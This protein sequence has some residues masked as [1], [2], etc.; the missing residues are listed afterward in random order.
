M[1]GYEQYKLKYQ[2]LSGSNTRLYDPFIGE[3]GN[4]FGTSKKKNNSFTNNYMTEGFFGRVMYDYA[5]KYFVNASLR[6]DA[7]SAFAPGH[8]WGTFGSVGLAWQMN[9]E[10]FLKDVKWID[11]LKL[12]VSYGSVGNDQL[13]TTPYANQ[14]GE[15]YYYWADRY[16]P[17]YNEETGQFSVTM[18]QKGNENL[19]W[20]TH[21]DWNVGVDF[22]FFKNRLTGTI[23]YYNQKTV[24]LLWSKSLPLSSGLSVSSYYANIGE[25]VNRG[26][27]ISLEGTPIRTQNFEWS[28]NWNGTLNHNEITKLDPSLGEN[29]L[30]S[31]GRVLKVGGSVYE[32]FMVQY[33][34]V[35]HETGQAQWYQDVYY[36]A[37]GQKV[38]SAKAAD[39]AYTKK[40]LTTDITQATQYDC[41]STLPTI[42]GGFGTS[43]AAYGF[44]LS[45][46]FSY[47]L[48][49]KIY[50]GQYQALMHN[51]TSQGSA[52][53][54][55]LLNA[56]SETNKNSDIPRLSQAAADDPGIGSQTTQDRFLTSSNYLCLNNLTLGYTFP[57]A[58][59][60]PLELTNLRVYVAGENIFMLTKRK[61]LDPRFN[62]GIGSMTAGSGLAAGGYA[63]LRSI[64]AG[65]SLTF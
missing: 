63:A 65:I 45:A 9:K 27:E 41:G 15:Y 17:S 20:E 62:Y 60:R 14:I 58:L 46:Q 8:R 33:A 16:T 12:K 3:L 35:N 13:D 7:S 38:E 30:Q 50:D 24:D 53:H 5:D 51:G 29:G 31:S 43:V 26:V 55:D 36:N 32:A 61:G 10:D 34:G 40:E 59:I 57:K 23:E 18:S 56:W 1:A 47:Q 64:T 44:D 42:F 6:R 21:N 49:G 25:M 37:D 2:Y 4:A 19:T 28:I 48:G 22:G 52:M 11:L 54:K 39:Y